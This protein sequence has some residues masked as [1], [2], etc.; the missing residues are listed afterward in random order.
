MRNDFGASLG[1]PIWKDHTFFF[2]NGEVERFRTTRT[3][4]TTTPTAAFKTG[5][6]T[7]IDPTDG[8]QTPVDLVTPGNPNNISGLG[9]DPT[10]NKLLAVT[11]VGQADNGDGVSTTYFF[12]S[13][14]PLNQ[15]TLTGRFDHKL[16]DKHQL[17]VR[18][19]YG[20]SAEGDPFHDETLP[21]L[22]NT[23]VIATNHNGVISID[24]ALSANSANQLRG[25]YNQ[26]NA[27]F[28]CNHAG[29][30]ALTGVDPFGNGRD[31]N[32]PYFFNGNSFG[33]YDLV[34]DGQARL[35]STLLLA[36]TYSVVKGAHSIK[37]G[38][39]WRSVK[40][41]SYDNF[42]SREQLALN[43]YSTYGDPSYTFAGNPAS[44]SLTSFE[45]LVWGAQGAVANDNEYQFFN[46]AGVRRPTD[47]THFVQHEWAVFAQDT[48][49]VS[50]RF[51]AILG[52][53]YGFNG[54]PYEAAANFAN[55]Y[56]DA[57]AP[58]PANGF[59]FRQ[60]GPGTGHQL[61][62]DS[63]GLVEPRIGFAYDPR[64]DG[65]IA[66]RGGYGIFHDRVF[67]NLFGNAKS[68]P[69]FQADSNLFPFTG[70]SPTVS[71]NPFPG[72]LTPSASIV[73][74]AFNEPV[75]IDSHL[76]MPTSQSYNL[77]IQRQ[78]NSRMTAE[79]DYV[80]SHSTHAL[81][82]VDGAPPQPALVQALIASG[83]DPQPCSATR[84]TP[85]EPM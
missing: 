78:L 19:I 42:F 15:Y 84:S 4:A 60:V 82:E 76:R 6:F 29:F 37:F 8:S 20:H 63:W 53:R 81:R 16:T 21:G 45:D 54:V 24:S 23:Q 46:A 55:F 39:E 26:N 41:G 58:Q 27:G 74:G 3:N 40:D 73:N 31:I 61:Y 7:Y 17:S 11:P 10:I 47:L 62:E 9:Q 52:L 67:D 33:C 68:N 66:I 2:L 48:W 13:P 18:Y 1:G 77:G 44:P 72:T 30:D 14:D 35:S 56:G 75:V 32:I 80:G 5:V 34:S 28:F 71:A 69:P 50:P 57:S 85:E 64:G 43:A 25:S 49:K 59:T 12:P 65:K 70:T 79:V 38:G 22:G 51:T 36:D 83:I